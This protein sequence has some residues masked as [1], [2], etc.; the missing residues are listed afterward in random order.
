MSVKHQPTVEAYVRQ[1]AAITMALENLKEFVDT[2]PAPDENGHIPNVDY[3]YTGSTGCLF[4]LLTEAM[5]VADAMS[6]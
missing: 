4:E 3:G 1:H 2:M 6:K 5:R